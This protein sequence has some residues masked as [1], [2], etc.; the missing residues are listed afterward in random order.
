MRLP[1][2]TELKLDI[3]PQ[4]DETTCGPTCLHAVYGYYDDNADLTEIVRETRRLESGGTYAAF[5]GTH[6][7][8]RGY[9]ATIYS[10]NLQVFDPSWFGTRKVDLKERLKQQM[11][12]KRWARLQPVQEAYLEYVT[13]GG[14]I[15]LRDLTRVLLRGMLRRGIPIITG[16]S[17]TYLYRVPREYGPKDVPDDVRG[18][19]AGHFVVLTGYR[20]RDRLVRVS[21][22]YLPH[23]TGGHHYWVSIDRL[24]N[25]ILLGTLTFDANLLVVAPRAKE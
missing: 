7:L 2:D 20:R 5:L 8:K 13:A 14:R 12:A 19:P 18:E 6:A 25:A 23:S 11:A 17:S 16:L 24:I 22:P 4:P 3:L 21:D 15:R 1:L 10:W 9:E